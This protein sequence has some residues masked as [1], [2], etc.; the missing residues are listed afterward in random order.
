MVKIHTNNF[1]Q[2]FCQPNFML[3]GLLFRNGTGTLKK[4]QRRGSS[5]LAG[6][7][8]RYFN[9]LWSLRRFQQTLFGGCGQS[10]TKHV[11]QIHILIMKK[12]TTQTSQSEVKFNHMIF[13]LQ[14]I[15]LLKETCFTTHVN[16]CGHVCIYATLNP[17]HQFR[18]IH[19]G[20]RPSFQS[21]NCTGAFKHN[22]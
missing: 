13:P 21:F 2:E 20:V 6:R 12:A 10:V 15:P 5:S 18:A 8:K 11:R 7:H 4:T 17:G 22:Q 1:T 9:W 16:I 3:T 14:R 19:Q